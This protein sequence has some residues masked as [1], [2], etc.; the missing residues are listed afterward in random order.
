MLPG[1][2]IAPTQDWGILVVLHLY[3]YARGRRGVCF[4]STASRGDRGNRIADKLG[5][6]SQYSIPIV[7]LMAQPAVSRH[8]TALYIPTLLQ[9]GFRF[10]SL[11]RMIHLVLIVFGLLS[12]DGLASYHRVLGSQR[13][14]VI[15]WPLLVSVSPSLLLPTLRSWLK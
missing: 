8:V 5:S 14:P 11:L 1:G 6:S 12:R 15:R 13:G 10:Q 3:F 2:A 4:T 7:L 9:T